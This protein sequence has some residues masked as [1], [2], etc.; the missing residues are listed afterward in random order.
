MRSPNW[1]AKRE[2]KVDVLR[3]HNHLDSYHEYRRN[4]YQWTDLSKIKIKYQFFSFNRVVLLVQQQL[5]TD[6]FLTFCSQHH[7]SK[8]CLI[9]LGKKCTIINNKKVM[10]QI[11]IWD[12]HSCLQVKACL[13]INVNTQWFMIVCAYDLIISS[14]FINPTLTIN[15]KFVFRAVFKGLSKVILWLLCL[16]I[17]LKDSCQFFNHWDAK[18]KPIAPCT[19][20]LSSI[21]AS[22][23]WLLGILIGSAPVVI[24]R[25]NCSGFGFSTVI[26]KPLY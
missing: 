16:V 4:I 18:A 26:W 19:R 20:D 7:V 2:K 15:I 8:Y 6:K 17:G 13:N 5:S 1:T 3:N 21:R 9:V 12:I 25:S 23:M 14:L 11:S 22:Y 10:F 24:G